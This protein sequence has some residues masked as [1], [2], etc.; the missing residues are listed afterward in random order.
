MSTR[1]AGGSRYLYEP[2]EYAPAHT[3]EANERV[4][5]ERWKGLEYRL[6]LI[7][8]G[9]E[10]LEK[11]VWLTIFGVSAAILSETVTGFLVP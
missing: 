7:E 6:G 3:V 10:R 4:Q 2:F 9:I 8:Q 1:K 11:R 5:Q